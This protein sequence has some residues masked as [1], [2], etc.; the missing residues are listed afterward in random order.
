MPLGFKA[1]TEILEEQFKAK[2][3]LDNMKPS[4]VARL[5]LV[6]KNLGFATPNVSVGG[7]NDAIA[8]QLDDYLRRGADPEVPVFVN[9]S[10]PEPD[11]SVSRTGIA[12]TLYDRFADGLWQGFQSTC[13]IVF[14]GKSFDTLREQAF[15]QIPGLDRVFDKALEEVASRGLAELEKGQ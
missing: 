11:G 3:T 1:N 10:W 4:N 15:L 2:R 9:L 14:P 8:L 6:I 7:D 12:A 13:A 5:L